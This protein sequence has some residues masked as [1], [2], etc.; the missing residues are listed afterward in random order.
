MLKRI[1]LVSRRPGMADDHFVDH[2][3]NKH[4]ALV[5]QLTG[6]LGYRQ[7]LVVGTVPLLATAYQLDG[8]AELWFEDAEAMTAAMSS[9]AGRTLPGDEQEFLGS[10]ASFA[11]NATDPQGPSH[12][13]YVICSPTSSTTS[14]I[15]AFGRLIA[16]IPDLIGHEQSV[17]E[18]VIRRPRPPLP[19]QDVG[20]FAG[21]RFAAHVEPHDVL[22]GS[23]CADFR[24][25]LESTYKTVSIVKVD[26]HRVV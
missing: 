18:R 11:T 12:S 3:R 20:I 5:K 1:S 24:S 26:Q 13:H 4:S 2:W 21:I 15:D 17:V 22:A 7:T 23:S 6:L 9:H 25:Q 14:D 16:Q 10:I 19:M 8:F